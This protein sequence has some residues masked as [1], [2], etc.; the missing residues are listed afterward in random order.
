[1]SDTGKEMMVTDALRGMELELQSAKAALRLQKSVIDRYAGS[2]EGSKSL[3]KALE[4]VD[5]A[6]SLQAV[7]DG[8]EESIK[9][10]KEEFDAVIDAWYGVG[11]W[12]SKAA[13]MAIEEPSSDYRIIAARIGV[14]PSYVRALVSDVRRKL[15]R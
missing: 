11:T 15:M 10:T 6:K 4:A 8:L 12:Q 13:R 3:M 14:R 2:R 7:I 9:T 5:K 1:M